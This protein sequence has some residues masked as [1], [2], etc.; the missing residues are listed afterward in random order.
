MDLLYQSIRTFLVD[1]Q[2]K[3]VRQNALKDMFLSSQSS[4]S[5]A[6]DFL[7]PGHFTASGFV[8]TPDFQQWVLIFHPRF[9]KWIQP[10]G[11]LEPHDRDIVD[12]AQREIVEESG[13][14]DLHFTGHM[15]LDLHEVPETSKLGAHQHWDIQLLFTHD[16]TPLSGDLRGQ[17]IKQAHLSTAQSDASVL[18][19]LD[20]LK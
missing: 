10:G 2:P 17:W 8:C 1:Y 9:Q 14:R 11:H 12:A 20:S 19:F 6:R 5:C 7:N 15:L 13:L 3:T 18:R 4:V 16:I